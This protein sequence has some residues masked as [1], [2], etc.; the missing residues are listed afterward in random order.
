MSRKSSLMCVWL[1]PSRV[2]TKHSYVQLCMQYVCN[3]S[4]GGRQP[5]GQAAEG[6]LRLSHGGGDGG[7]G[8]GATLP[9]GDRSTCKLCECS[10]GVT[11]SRCPISTSAETCTEKGRSIPTSANQPHQPA[12]SQLTALCLH[13]PPPPPPPPPPTTT[14]TTI[15]SGNRRTDGRHGTP[16]AAAAATA[17][18]GLAV[19]YS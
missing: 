14:T 11:E 17:P 19:R 1:M 6:C 13:V 9:L 3:Q 18:A 5:R 7:G 8:G 15:M 10:V 12:S 4:L 16:P 2:P